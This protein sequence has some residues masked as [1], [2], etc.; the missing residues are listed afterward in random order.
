MEDSE[1]EE[2]FQQQVPE[3]I[4]GGRHRIFIVQPDVKWGSRKQRLTTGNRTSH[5]DV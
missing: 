1:V 2:L 3:G 5:V 4:A